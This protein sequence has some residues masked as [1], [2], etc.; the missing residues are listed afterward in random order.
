MFVFRA[1]RAVSRL[2]WKMRRSSHVASRWAWLG[3][4]GSLV[5]V[6]KPERVFCFPSRMLGS[7]QRL[8]RGSLVRS[9]GM[10]LVGSEARMKEGGMGLVW[11]VS[12]SGAAV[13]AVWNLASW[14]SRDLS[15]V[16]VGS[17]QE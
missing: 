8:M 11:G 3:S 15:G 13:M 12:A 4:C 2:W 7:V 6:L 14:R 16:G 10:S 9:A 5:R 17:G 1:V